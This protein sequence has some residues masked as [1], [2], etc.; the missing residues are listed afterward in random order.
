MTEK[1]I[2]KC[3]SSECVGKE[4]AL[5]TESRNLTIVDESGEIKIQSI[6]YTYKCLSCHTQFKS[7]ISPKQKKIIHG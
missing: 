3:P 4:F 1:N 6:V 7:E 5:I 2:I